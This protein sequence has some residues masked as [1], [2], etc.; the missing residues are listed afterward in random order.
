[1][2]TGSASDMLSRIKS[3][4]PGGWFPAT[5]QDSATTA[6]PVLDAALSG[7]AWGLAWFWGFLAYVARQARIATA[8]GINLD[9]AA[10]DF[11]GAGLV[12][13]GAEADDALRARILAS[14]FPK[15]STRQSVID[16]AGAAAGG[17]VTI[18]EPGYALDAGGW[19]IGTS[20]FDA[21]GAAGW[22]TRTMPFQAF[23]AAP[24]GHQAAV[25][26]A[27]EQARPVATIIW[28]RA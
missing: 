17:A 2:S 20:G 24:P 8:S 13:A 10:A 5:G 15:R 4:L 9:M 6:T 25:Y 19:D 21:A 7:P 16:A 12:R 3:V 22:G 26:A 1:M 28:T 11:F 14:L 27:V 18:F 23:L